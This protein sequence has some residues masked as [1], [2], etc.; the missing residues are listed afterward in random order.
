M[1]K[2]TSY[3]TKGFRRKM[4][5]QAFH[6]GLIATQGQEKVIKEL[7]GPP[8]QSMS[9][10]Y[11]EEY[12][13]LKYLDETYKDSLTFLNGIAVSEKKGK[14]NPLTPALFALHAYNQN[15]K[16]TFEKHVHHLQ[17]IMKTY[18]E[19]N[20]WNYNEGVER[21]GITAPWVSGIS[22]GIIA[23]VFIRKYKDSKEEKFLKIAKGAI[24]YCLNEEN[25]ITR[26]GERGL[27]I[28]EY[29]L[30]IGKGVLNGFIFFLIAL[31]ELACMGI[32]EEEFTAGIE[33]LIKELPSFHKGNYI[34]YGKHIPDLGNPLYD[35]IHFHQLNALHFL[36][37][38][39]GFYSLKDYWRRTSVTVFDS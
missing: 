16:E 9:L 32:H 17:N 23:S 39:S 19:E 6:K 10:K 28:E 2:S 18:E 12:K 8:K 24:S 36:T 4:L 22:Q 3:Y 7:L 34:L 38:I 37:S 14:I 21:F 25:G 1:R 31:G 35:R 13:A 29:P 20:Y 30:G 11:S 26:K 5:A 27:W 15:D 33:T